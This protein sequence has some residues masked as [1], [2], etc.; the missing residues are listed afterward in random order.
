[1]F[2]K[3]LTFHVMFKNFFNLK[4]QNQYACIYECSKTF[5]TFNIKKILKALRAKGSH[6]VVPMCMLPNPCEY[7]YECSKKS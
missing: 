2:K 1:M 4:N 3:I 5:S 7:V 6:S